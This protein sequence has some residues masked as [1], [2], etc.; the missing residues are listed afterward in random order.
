MAQM[1]GTDI[2]AFGRILAQDAST[3]SPAVS[4]PQALILLNDVLLRFNGDVEKKMR[5]AFAAE[6]GMTFA[7]NTP[8][9]HTT[10]DVGEIVS[11]HPCDSATGNQFVTPGLERWTV[12][13]MQDIYQDAGAGTQTGSATEWFAYAWERVADN[14]TTTQ[15]NQVTVYVWPTLNRTRYLT[16][17]V[18]DYET[19]TAL[20]EYPDLTERHGRL[21]GRLLAWE[22]ARLH[23]RDSEFLGQILAPVPSAVLNAYFESGIKNGFLPSGVKETGALDG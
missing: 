7:A 21:V 23:T 5:Y 4:D 2:V 19:L 13:Q 11:A 15:S 1:S 20:T 3:V 8:Y 22:M 10:V 12:R 18:G 9:I 14:S 17:K 16:L 6:T